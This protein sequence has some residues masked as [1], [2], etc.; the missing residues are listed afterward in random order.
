MPFQNMDLIQR[1][2]I[3]ECCAL[4]KAPDGDWVAKQIADRGGREAWI[5]HQLVFLHRFLKYATSDNG[6]DTDYVT[7]NRLAHLEQ[8]LKIAAKVFGI[9]SSMI[10]Q[11]LAKV[12]D[13]NLVA[14]DWTMNAIGAF[15]DSEVTKPTILFSSSDIASFVSGDSSYG[16]NPIASNPR[17][18]GRYI[19]AHLA[20]L[21]KLYG[22][23]Q[24]K[25]VAN[26]QMY[27]ADPDKAK[28]APRSIE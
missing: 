28:N 15:I 26:K 22:M 9:N 3:F 8:A 2:A 14:N 21:N 11:T 4:G 1:A 7:S 27:C 6:W 17:K 5:A 13:N 10:G 24:I 18:L 19:T 25:V 20:T 16:D 12:Q 23:R